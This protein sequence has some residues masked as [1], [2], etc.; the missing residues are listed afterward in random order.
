MQPSWQNLSVGIGVLC[1][2]M[3]AWFA[4][5]WL[6]FQGANLWI[7][8]IGAFLIVAMVGAALVLWLRSRSA[9]PASPAVSSGDAGPGSDDILSA[10]REAETRIARASKL[11]QG[12]RLATLPMLF[13]LG[14]S[15][16]GKTSVVM[17]SGLEPELLS[18]H[19]FQ[20]GGVTS[21]RL[22]NIWF[23]RGAVFV[24][25]GG[26][27]LGDANAWSRLLRTLTPSRF[28]S[29][30]RDAP[31]PPRAAIVCFDCETLARVSNPQEVT[32]HARAIRARLE[33]ISQTLGI[34][35]PVYVIFTR[36][37]R[38]PYF[39]DYFRNLSNEEVTQVL[40]VTVPVLAVGSSGVYAEQES[41]R[42]KAA[43]TSIFHSMAECRPGLL[44]REFNDPS[45][46]G[47]YEFPREFEKLLPAF[48]QF[49]VELCRPSHLRSG[50]FLRG[51]YFT[52][53]RLVEAQSSGLA[54]TILTTKA[55][56]TS[57]AAGKFSSNATAIFRPEESFQATSW[58]NRTSPGGGG[59]EANK[60]RQWAFLT[61]IFSHVIL[62]DRSA[63]GASGS[64][65]K[66][67]TGRRILYGAIT[68]FALTWIVGLTVSF[69]SN[70]ALEH[71]V[72]TAAA[73]LATV[74]QPA[75]VNRA[76]LDDLR[77]L[78][79]ARHV[80]ERL[81]GY[82]Q[83]GHPWRLGWG[84]YSGHDLYDQMRRVYFYRLDE[85][86]L[87]DT[88][89][90]MVAA[91]RKLP[92]CTASAKVDENNLRIFETLKAYLMTSSNPEKSNPEF[93]GPWLADAWSGNEAEAERHQL[94][95][96]QFTYYAVE[97]RDDNPLPEQA[98]PAA[99]QQART[100]LRLCNEAEPKYRELLAKA[101]QNFPPFSFP[102][103][104][105]DSAGLITAPKAVRGA[106]TRPAWDFVMKT[107]PNAG[108]FVTDDW[109][110]G[111]DSTS[112]NNMEGIQNQIRQK[113]AA[114]YIREWREFLR[115]AGVTK[116]RGASDASSKLAQMSDNRSPL[117]SLLCEVSEN[118]NVT[119]SGD[120]VVPAFSPVREVVAPG[121]T[122][123]LLS[124]PQ[125]QAYVQALLKSKDCFD[126][127][128]S[129]A[130]DEGLKKCNAQLSQDLKPLIALMV[131]S[132]DHDGNIDQTVR[133]LLEIAAPP[134]IDGLGGFCQALN[135]L[136]AKYPFNPNG[137]AEA[138]FEEF[139]RF[140]FPKT[141]MLSKFIEQ[142]KDGLD[143]RNDR[144][145]A[146]SGSGIAPGFVPVINRLLEVQNSLFP[147]DAS[148]MQYQFSLKAFFPDLP[149]GKVTLDGQTMT[150]VANGQGSKEFSWPGSTGEAEIDIES[151]SYAHKGPWAA[152][153]LFEPFNWS[154]VEG[155]YRLTGYL[156]GAGDEPLYY[157]GKRINLQF[158]FQTRDE[159]IFR[160]G[161][162]SSLH[163][164]A[165]RQ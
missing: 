165:G 13:I 37:D 127:I 108:Q 16:T 107:I 34:N 140:F 155:G 118:T 104:Y 17:Q 26:A 67:H 40:G 61:H 142:N 27:L 113:Y 162:L 18:G 23:A 87:N 164:P 152:F 25:L 151:V 88:R 20:E 56:S 77:N 38:L 110:L 65:T 116:F 131:K 9:K 28:R 117:L 126:G 60:I 138:T 90:Q 53:V 141:G 58:Q 134:R 146:K 153:R 106:F 39:E 43:L 86:L 52:G 128:D 10:M 42:L 14:E 82:E 45:K 109:V 30:L 57:A 33:Q 35:F 130:A 32:S 7:F 50:P 64:S 59:G 71:D 120:V 102:K 66:T 2:A 94:A 49:L 163:C 6:N 148:K 22:A 55:M 145:Y 79:F 36:S 137:R 44:Y 24:E 111:P 160:K 136:S 89:E 159:P 143:F 124:Q 81:E 125:T 76:T 95:K 129:A 154:P 19:V 156:K 158:E 149:A 123:N 41:K 29:L 112:V 83:N 122:S 69:F 78:D 119:P 85:L 157:A 46:P 135:S 48:T 98:D 150:I 114:D 139:N 3:F 4:G 121:C 12:T 74:R 47:I 133:K 1:T 8:R 31:A 101:D 5:A 11:P 68:A 80:L 100:Y 99:V 91:M 147:A 144:Y 96:D 62:Q 63:L 70:R 103:N 21:T 132:I 72:R 105:P 54:G 97:L 73:G 93:L 161:Y 84:L 15:G 51:F 75:A 115:S 92:S